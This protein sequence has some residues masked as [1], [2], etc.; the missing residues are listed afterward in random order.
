MKRKRNSF[1][2]IF[3]L[4]I[5]LSSCEKT[6]TD[7]VVRVNEF[8]VA[9][10]KFLEK[11]KRTF[12]YQQQTSFTE[13]ELKEFAERTY[14]ND[15]LFTVEGYDLGIAQEEDVKETIKKRKV[16]IIGQK[17][18]PLFKRVIPQNL[19]AQETEEKISEYL[20]SI[21]K[22]YNFKIDQDGARLF[23]QFCQTPRAKVKEQLFDPEF[24][25][26]PDSVL[27]V[28][29]AEKSL[30]VKQ[31]LQQFSRDFISKKSKINELSDVEHYILEWFM[32]N[33]F[34]LEMIDLG[35]DTDPDVL[36][37]FV[38][39]EQNIVRGECEKRLTVR[40]IQIT[41][42]EVNERY[43]SEKEK[44]SSISENK[45]KNEIRTKIRMEKRMEKSDTI[46]KALGK[47]Y[48]VEFNDSLFSSMSEELTKEKNG[49][50]K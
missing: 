50:S 5:L 26:N 11:Y 32:P 23:L 21:V 31:V 20:K 15:L 35:L 46:I 12:N 13:K 43:E 48:N 19:D 33:L 38:Q 17:D 39:S 6:Q 2:L 8:T 36:E 16:M 45:A 30:N 9:P 27:F 28:S 34:E 47:K 29:Y 18:G 4:F 42:Q 41:K 40:K 14:V 37:E 1:V 7:W 25:P 24:K 3:L 49:E 10:K 22:K 44:W